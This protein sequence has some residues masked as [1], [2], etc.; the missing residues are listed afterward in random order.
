MTS[1]TS[2]MSIGRRPPGAERQPDRAVPG[3]RFGGPG[4][5]EEVLEEDRRP[6]VHDG[7]PGPVQHLL[8]QPMLP[9]LG[10]VGHLGQAHLRHGHLGDV[11]E[12]LQVAAL[13]ATAAAVTVASR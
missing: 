13:R 7:Q 9:L 5:E 3:D 8:G 10:R 12:H 4:R 1:A 2:R 11:D 6:D